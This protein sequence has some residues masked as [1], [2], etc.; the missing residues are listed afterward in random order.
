MT[1]HSNSFRGKTGGRQTTLPAAIRETAADWIARRDAGLSPAEERAFADWQEA[2]PRH[3]QAVVRLASVWKALDR[4]LATG[5]ADAVLCELEGRAGRRRR[6][7]VLAAAAAVLL[8]AAGLGWRT[9]QGESGLKTPAIASATLHLPRLQALPDGSMVELREGAAVAV[10]FTPQQRRIVLD[11]GEAYFKVAKNPDRPFVVVAG[12]VEVRAV[13]TA[14]SV[15]RGRSEV[16]VLV[17]EGQVA[18]D[19]AAGV[20]RQPG[21]PEA[22]RL[23]VGAGD[24][25]IVRF[26]PQRETSQVDAMANVDLQTR[27]GWRS[28]RLEF[29]GTPL[30]EAVALM[31]RHNRVQFVILDPELARMRVSGIFGAVNTDAFIRLLE[32]SFNVQ[33]ERQGPDEIVLRRRP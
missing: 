22:S 14:F 27:L 7:G 26:S 8:L 21:S 12:G 13:G 5:S 25:A 3:R 20:A 15:D 18:V 1:F 9:L 2:D 28:P 31:N 6:A 10:E 4:P 24:G 17:T 32:I 30:I 11:R 33:A 16:E 29:S 19:V 23:L